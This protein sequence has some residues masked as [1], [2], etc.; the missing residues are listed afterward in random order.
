MTIDVVPLSGAIGAAVTGVPLAA[1]DDEQ[2]ELIHRAF[3]DHCML[4]FPEQFLTV[5]EH[6]A[7]AGRFGQFSISPFVTYLDSHPC[8]LPLKNR[9]KA[10]AVTENWHTDSA[11]LAEPPALNVL[12]AREV[13]IGGDTMWSNQY[14]SYDRLSDG[15]K[16]MLDGV[17]A[18]YTGARLASLVGSDDVPAS[19]HPIVRT[20]PE[21]GRK[22][23]YVSRPVDSVPRFEG[24]TDEESLPLLRF[25]YDHSI[26]PDNIYRHHWRNGDVVMWDNRCTMHYAVH[27]YGEATRDIHR[28]SIKG[29]VP[30]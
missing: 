3:L 10:G 1:I 16:A 13:P 15:M 8:V 21:T 17:R 6:V 4:V 27:D 25:L 28:I 9:G 14:R 7:F 12:S 2:F 11:F 24:M 5:D 22:A 18:E 29:T 26:Q 23:L 19:F 30:R 20:H